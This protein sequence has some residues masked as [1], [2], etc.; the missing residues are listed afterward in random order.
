MA[1]FQQVPATRIHNASFSTMQPGGLLPTQG[2]SSCRTRSS[3][4]RFFFII[5]ST[6]P[7]SFRVIV[8]TGDFVEK[9]GLQNTS[10]SKRVPPNAL[11]NASLWNPK[12]LPT[13]KYKTKIIKNHQIKRTWKDWCQEAVYRPAAAWGTHVH[14]CFPTVS[15]LY[16]IH[17]IWHCQEMVKTKECRLMMI[18]SGWFTI[19]TL[20]K[21]EGGEPYWNFILKFHFCNHA[22]SINDRYSSSFHVI[23]NQMKIKYLRLAPEELSTCQTEAA[24]M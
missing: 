20:L 7:C 8:L 23:G 1:D 24:H 9:R 12:W 3:N 14:R 22:F 13:T 6:S 11:Q 21:M 10:P 2:P 17:G 19:P 18:S 4:V 15:H 16:K 5:C